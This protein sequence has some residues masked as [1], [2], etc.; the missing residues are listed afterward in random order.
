M[1]SSPMKIELLPAALGDC[2]LVSSPVVRRVW[3]MLIDTGPDETYL[4]D[5]SQSGFAA[6]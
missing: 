5:C 1:A 2:L 6:Q 4:A 3:R